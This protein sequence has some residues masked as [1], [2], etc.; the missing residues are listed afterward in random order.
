MGVRSFLSPRIF[1]PFPSR[2]QLLGLL[3]VTT[4]ARNVSGSRKTP[5]AHGSSGP[6]VRSHR[7][8]LSR[9]EREAVASRRRARACAPPETTGLGWRGDPGPTTGPC[10][11]SVYIKLLLNVFAYFPFH[12]LYKTR[13]I[14]HS[15]T[16]C[17]QTSEPSS[18]PALSTGCPPRFRWDPSLF[19]F[20]VLF[21]CMFLL[22]FHGQKHDVSLPFE[23]D[24]AGSKVVCSS[25]LRKMIHLCSS[26]CSLPSGPV[27]VIFSQIQSIFFYR[28]YRFQQQRADRGAH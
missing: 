17:D 2:R 24:T 22:L 18:A 4:A 9:S 14:Y 5:T 19:C 28:P 27:S 25:V 3:D 20:V 11:V 13:Q 8:F 6:A 15:L 10:S 16:D 12:L 21:G 23:F 7:I 1:D 26:F